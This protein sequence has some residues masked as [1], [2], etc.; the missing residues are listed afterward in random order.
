MTKPQSP[1]LLGHRL[2]TASRMADS[3]VQAS[4]CFTKNKQTQPRAGVLVEVE[5]LSLGYRISAELRSR[6]Q[7]P[8]SV[9]YTLP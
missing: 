6:E 7:S 9:E 5:G 4:T 3:G 8:G 1:R 2:Q